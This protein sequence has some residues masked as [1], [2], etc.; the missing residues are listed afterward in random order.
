MRALYHDGLRGHCPRRTS[1]QFAQD[2]LKLGD[3]LWKSVFSDETRLE[4]SGHM[5]AA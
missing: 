4:L 1:V 5:D 3:E 2:H